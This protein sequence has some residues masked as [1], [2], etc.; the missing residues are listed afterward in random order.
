MDEIIASGFPVSAAVGVAA[1]LIALAIGVPLGLLMGWYRWLDHIVTH[2]GRAL[3]PQALAARPWPQRAL[4]RLA[5][6]V[7]RATLFVTGHRY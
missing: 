1:L 6:M 5:F 7:M 4:D 2:D 3:Q